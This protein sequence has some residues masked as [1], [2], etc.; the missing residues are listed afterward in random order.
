MLGNKR[1]LKPA[2]DAVVFGAVERDGCMAF[3]RRSVLRRRNG[4]PCC[5]G[6]DND[7]G[8]LWRLVDW[9]PDRR[10]CGCHR[11]R[12]E[13]SRRYRTLRYVVAMSGRYGLMVSSVCRFRQ[14]LLAEPCSGDR[15]A[16]WSRADRHVL[17]P[18]SPVAHPRCCMGHRESC[19]DRRSLVAF[20]SQP[21]CSR[22]I[23]NLMEVARGRIF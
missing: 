18:S 23:K 7:M 19:S 1:R 6:T 13:L 5:T 9:H 20:Q 2:S 10:G 12:T 15:C 17:P 22:Q 16:G 14:D 8:G 4:M 11:H 21:I 3:P